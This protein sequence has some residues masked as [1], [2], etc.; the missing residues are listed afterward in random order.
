MISAVARTSLLHLDQRGNPRERTEF[1]WTPGG[2]T[3]K[4]TVVEMSAVCEADSIAKSGG[5]RM[6]I[7]G[8]A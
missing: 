4:S 2:L 3:G 8:M 5:Y 1:A 6:K 7:S